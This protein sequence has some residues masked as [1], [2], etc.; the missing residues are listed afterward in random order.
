MPKRCHGEYRI[1][2]CGFESPCWISVFAPS[3]N[4]YCR[5]PHEGKRMYAHRVMYERHKGEIPAGLVIDHLCR[6]TVCCNPEHLQAVTQAVNCHRS[7]RSKITEEI[8][9]QIR[10]AEGSTLK[11]GRDFDLDP[12]QVWRIRA[13]EAWA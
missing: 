1:E 7:S 3:S 11:I 9:Q 10:E 6:N 8:A 13:G 2:D 12:G 4:G 5:M